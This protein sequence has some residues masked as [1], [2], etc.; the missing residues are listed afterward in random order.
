VGITRFEDIVAWQQ[1]RILVRE[2]YELTTRPQFARDY[3]LSDQ[4]RRAAVSSM[5][6]IVEGFER[7][8]P[9]E[10]LQYLSIARASSAEV[11]SLLYVALDVGYIDENDF[12][13]LMANASSLTRLIASFRASIDRY[14]K[15]I[16]EESPEYDPDHFGV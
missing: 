14:V 12:E 10:N 11:R 4:I 13:R 7:Y 9:R 1:A 6:N 5:S 15:G 3:G 16:K 8:S 2:I